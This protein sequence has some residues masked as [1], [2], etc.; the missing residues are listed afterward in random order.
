MQYNN[1]QGFNVTSSEEASEIWTLLGQAFGGD[2]QVPTGT[3]AQ[4]LEGRIANRYENGFGPQR[5]V[6]MA[7]FVAAIKTEINRLFEEKW[8]DGCNV[9]PFE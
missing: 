5:F 1:G 9:L 7:K 4:A 3:Y 2:S 8:G 6:E